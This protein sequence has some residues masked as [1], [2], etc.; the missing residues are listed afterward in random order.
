[1]FLA[2]RHGKNPTEL[3][4]SEDLFTS[5]VFGFLKH[6]D[7]TGFLLPFLRDQPG[8]DVSRA[9]AATVV[10]L[11]DLLNGLLVQRYGFVPGMESLI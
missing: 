8:L 6:A 4:N 3:I 11:W 1:M 5:D 9:D 7:R 2:A 10:Y